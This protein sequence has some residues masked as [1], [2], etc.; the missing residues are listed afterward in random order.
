M[1]DS[2]L[3]IEGAIQEIIMILTNSRINSAEHQQEKGN[4]E[5]NQC[6]F[7]LYP[8]LMNEGV[9]MICGFSLEAAELHWRCVMGS[10]KSL[11]LLVA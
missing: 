1:K 5:Y 7:T 6:T 9:R 2:A 11:Y 4:C 8:F 10:S 3:L